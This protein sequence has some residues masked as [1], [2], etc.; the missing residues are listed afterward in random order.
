MAGRSREDGQASRQ[1]RGAREKKRAVN[2]RINDVESRLWRW[3]WR[4][5][6]VQ[7][8][9]ASYRRLES[10]Q[11]TLVST[12]ELVRAFQLGIRG[13][14]CMDRR[15]EGAETSR[16]RTVVVSIGHRAWLKGAKSWLRRKPRVQ[17]YTSKRTEIKSQL[18]RLGGRKE[19]PPHRWRQF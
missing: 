10:R 14:F 7:I 13:K 1:A 16:S 5:H 6:Q 3:I 8:L 18:G 19:K 11:Q 15:P 4:T 2:E 12:E 17:R 9:V